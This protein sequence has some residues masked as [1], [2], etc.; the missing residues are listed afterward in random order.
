MQHRHMTGHVLH[1][2]PTSDDR[3]DRARLLSGIGTRLG[4][5]GFGPQAVSPSDTVVT[6]FPRR[7]SV[8]GTKRATEAGHVAKSVPPGH[9]GDDGC[10]AS[11][12]QILPACLKPVGADP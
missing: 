7:Q 8:L 9:A 3:P 10:G 4:S 6:P 1:M 12:G 5:V 2:G 11:L